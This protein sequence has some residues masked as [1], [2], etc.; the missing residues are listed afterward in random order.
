LRFKDAKVPKG[1]VLPELPVILAVEDEE[2]LQTVVHDA[3]EEGG[4]DVVISA[5]ADE[6]LTLFHS[7]V[8]KYSALV[9]DVN[10]KGA[11]NGWELARQVREIDPAFPVVYITGAAADEWGSQ[12]VPNSIL[13]Q[14]PFAPAQLVTAVYQLLSSGG[15]TT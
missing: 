2:L 8:A 7:E 9:S 12:G 1:D 11:K 6:A 4:F 15:T 10:L 3:L 13:L 5:S 14:K